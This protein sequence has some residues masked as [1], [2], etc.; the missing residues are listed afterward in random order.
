MMRPEAAEQ[1]RALELFA[2]AGA[3]RVDPPILQPAETLLALYGEEIRGRAYTARDPLVGELMLRP[4]FTVPL[5]Q[6]HLDR[7]AGAARYAYAGPVFRVQEVDTKRPS[8]YTQVGFES[9]GGASPAQED[10]EVF[11]LFAQLLDGL[12]VRVATGDIGILIAAVGG[13]SASPRRRA[14]LLRHLWRP[15]RFRQLLD[16]FSGRRAPP[17]HRAAL[18][19]RAGTGADIMDPQGTMIGLRTEAEIWDRVSAFAEEAREAPIPTEQAGL[20]DALLR[21][22]APLPEALRQLQGIAA[23]FDW[24][25]PAVD[26]LAARTQALAERGAEVA[27]LTFEGAYGRTSMEYYDGFVFGASAH[28]D[29]RP[30]VVLGGR[31]DALTRAMGRAVP[32]VGGVLRPALLAELRA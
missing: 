10:A 25:R 20:I 21:L 22:S 11:G 31:Y 16:Q 23:R 32:A 15:V 8:E 7:G 17:A 3:E 27:G 9:F 14:A 30:P 1:A 4:D 29:A 13:L 5:V 12:P 6:L 18:V 24:L 2:Q 19:A 26:R 28:S